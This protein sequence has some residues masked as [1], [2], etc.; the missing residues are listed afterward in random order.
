MHS[1]SV[2]L[3]AALSLVLCPL[4]FAASAA[5]WR[6]RAIYQV[7]TD[8][9]ARGDGSTTA[10]CDTA[11]RAYCGGNY[12]GIINQLDYI[13]GMGFD[14]LWISPITAQVEG[15]TPDGTAYHGYW[16][17]NLNKLNPNFG[18]ADDLKALSSA[19]HARGMLLML[20]VVVNHNGYNGAPADVDYSIFSPFNKAS[21]YHS[22]CTIDYSDTSNSANIEQC[23]MGDT[24]VPLPD[25]RTEDSDVAAGYQSWISHVVS[26][27]S[28]DGLRLDSMMEVNTGFWS[29]FHS[30]AGVFMLG[31]VYNG[32]AGYVCSFQ[33]YVPT[34]NYPT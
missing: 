20:D 24:S 8:R 30:A 13:Q 14:A 10:A 33:D 15:N 21:Q 3:V 31:E 1:G 9:F 26:E 23:W 5:D 32:D 19:L 7:M 22:Y 25:L 11:D 28:I 27:Y 17:Q 29:G 6:S 34:M 12:R 4:A 18:S 16:Q 2:R